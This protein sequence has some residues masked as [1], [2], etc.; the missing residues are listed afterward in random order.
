MEKLISFKE[1][2][3]TFFKED[4]AAFCKDNLVIVTNVAFGIVV[5]VMILAA[6]LGLRYAIV[7]VCFLVI[8]EALL[9]GLLHRAELWIHGVLILAEIIAGIIVGKTGLVILCLVVY[10]AATLV[11]QLK[12]YDKVYEHNKKQRNAV[13]EGDADTDTSEDNNEEGVQ[14]EE[15]E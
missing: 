15:A 5:L 6:T 3:V 11:L 1:K 2:L 4:V 8:I 7:P 14:Y 12:I 10:V 9:A 13:S